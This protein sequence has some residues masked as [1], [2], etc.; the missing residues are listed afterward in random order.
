MLSQNVRLC[1]TEA[2][3]ASFITIMKIREAIKTFGDYKASGVDEL[4]PCVFKQLGNNAIHW[5]AT[6]YRASYLL[7]YAPQQ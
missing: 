1:N 5:L 4:K 6:M 2:Q 7:G 3:E